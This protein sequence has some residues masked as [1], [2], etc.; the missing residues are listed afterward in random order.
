MKK[1]GIVWD[2]KVNRW[3]LQ[4]FEPLKNDIDIT[5]FVGE[6][7]DYDV[8]PVD[9]NIKQLTHIEE[10][11]LAIQKP[12]IVYKR[13][14][15]AP[16]KRMDFYYFSLQKYLKGVDAVYSCDITRSAYTLASL[17]D[18]LGFKLLL[19]WWENIPYRA[20]FDEKTSYH[21]KLIM[22]KVDM[23]LPFTETARKI[24]LLEG[25]PEE[26]V[27]V[28]YPGVDL[29]RFKPGPKPEDLL[30]Q[31]NIP[32]NSFVI[33]YVGKL[34]S[35]KGVHNLVYTAR[36]LKEKGVK[37]FVVAVAGK[38]A[39]KENMA[40]LIRETNTESHFRF[41]DFVSYDEMPDVHRMAD[42]FVLPSYP[43]MTWQEQF[44]MVLIEAMACGKPVISTNSGSIPE[45][46]G[47][48]GILISPGNFFQLAEIILN[49]M[50]NRGFALEVGNRGRQRV[51]TYFDAQKNAMKFYEVVKAL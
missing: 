37:D 33:L 43:T 26:K 47:D 48:A 39:Q 50:S 9:L 35:W 5:V 40:R 12:S 21:K 31:N 32:Q 38:G 44:G 34:V 3:V 6:R 45:V 25:V 22:E 29:E 28:V 1:L 11:S 18:E 13:I 27:E 23:F 16:Y 36:V 7:N 49:L 51:E 24:L 42:V 20:V 8:R 46:I 17:K 19:S 4:R 2:N 14:L 10:A 15:K 41:L 30:T